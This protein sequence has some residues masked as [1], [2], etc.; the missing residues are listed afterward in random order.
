[1][2]VAGP[3]E[4]REEAVWV[5]IAAYRWA[6]PPKLQ[7]RWA[8]LVG[9]MEKMGAT[10]V[11]EKGLVPQAVEALLAMEVARAVLEFPLGFVVREGTKEERVRP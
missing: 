4:G 3:A 6:C 8:F 9:Q 5:A 7:R 2:E 11:P 1:M 10:V